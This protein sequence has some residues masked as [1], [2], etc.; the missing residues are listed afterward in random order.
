MKVSYLI[1]T[2]CAA[3]LSTV[4]AKVDYDGT[5]VVR[6]AHTENVKTLIKRLNLATWGKDNGFI[7]VVLPRG[8]E[9]SGALMPKVMHRDLGASIAEEAAFAPYAGRSTGVVFIY[10][11]V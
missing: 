2:L 9:L 5:K 6:V 4:Q 7:D 3:L 8:L 11:Q 1:S 10:V